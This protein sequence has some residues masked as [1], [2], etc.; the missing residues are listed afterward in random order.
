MENG[1]EREFI[2]ACGAV[3]P[4]DGRLDY[5]ICPKMNTVEMSGFLRQV[6]EKYPED[7]ILMVVDGAG[8]HKAKALEIPADIQLIT[9]PPYSPQLNPQENV[10][11]EIREK[12]FPNR[13]FSVSG[14][15]GATGQHREMPGISGL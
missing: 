9:L 4:G 14:T 13:V 15:P 7:A 3:S 11:D 2:H 6:S 5:R 8:S 12:N 10:R 1:C